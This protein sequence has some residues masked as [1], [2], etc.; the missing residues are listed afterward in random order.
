MAE[1]RS[2]STTCFDQRSLCDFH[3]SFAHGNYGFAILRNRSSLQQCRTLINVALAFFDGFS[4]IMLIEVV[5]SHL[6]IA[7]RSK[8][9]SVRIRPPKTSLTYPISLSRDWMRD[10]KVTCDRMR[11]ELPQGLKFNVA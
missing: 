2:Q 10:G 8:P 6:P 4:G 9:S 11:R 7:I 1:H 3:P 5:I